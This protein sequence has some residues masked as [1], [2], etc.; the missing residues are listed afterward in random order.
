M[1]TASKRV[2]FLVL[3]AVALM[4][5]ASWVSYRAVGVGLATPSA[6]LG[7]LWL[8]AEYGLDEDTFRKVSDLH[9]AYFR[10]CEQR[11]HQLETLD[12][13]LLKDAVMARELLPKVEEE[14]AKE[15]A[16]CHDCR[17]AM[18]KHLYAVAQLMPETA[19]QRFL[20]EMTAILLPAAVHGERGSLKPR[21]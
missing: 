3:A 16:L 18:L 8:K 21:N 12:N 5:L 17:Q 2:G 6:G 20:A 9:A 1:N 13:Q 15:D 14:L 7:L 19:G 11:C 10:E 4:G